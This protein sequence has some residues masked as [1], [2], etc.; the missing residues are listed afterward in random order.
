LMR[1]IKDSCYNCIPKP[2]SHGESLIYEMDH[3]REN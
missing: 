3:A 1:T 2:R